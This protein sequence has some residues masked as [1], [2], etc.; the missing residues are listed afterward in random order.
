MEVWLCARVTCDELGRFANRKPQAAQEDREV[1]QAFRTP[2][3]TVGDLVVYARVGV[4]VHARRPSC[5]LEETRTPD[6]EE[7]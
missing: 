2:S 5:S 6:V 7:S 1:S 4:M 3:M